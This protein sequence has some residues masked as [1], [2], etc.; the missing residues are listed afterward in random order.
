MRALIARAPEDLKQGVLSVGDAALLVAQIPRARAVLDAAD[1]ALKAAVEI[2]GPI[3]LSDGRVYGP[4]TQRWKK[5][6]FAT[7]ETYQVLEDEIGADE[8]DA[9]FSTSAEAIED[10]VKAAHAA[11][12][13]KRQVAPTM[14]RLFARLF[15]AKAIT[16]EPVV[17]WKAH[18][19]TGKRALPMVED[20]APTLTASVE[21]AKTGT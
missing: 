13:I 21:A 7:R 11:R 4:Q 14:K 10:A 3:P 8:A 1:R 16:E 15:E 19:P 9:A 18:H 20:L 5:K 17:H 12:S 2:H 6:T